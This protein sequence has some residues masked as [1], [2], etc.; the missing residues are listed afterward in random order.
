MIFS[1]QSM[2]WKSIFGGNLVKNATSALIVVSAILLGGFGGLA[3]A[4]P[5]AADEVGP[6]GEQAP[7]LAGIKEAEALIIEAEAAQDEARA[8]ELYSEAAVDLEKLSDSGLSPSLA[9]RCLTLA[10]LCYHEAKLPSKAVRLYRRLVDEERFRSSEHRENALLFLADSYQQSF[11]FDEASKAYL[12]YGEEY[13]DGKE[14]RR[15][16][17]SAA[18]LHETAEDYLRAT[19]AV[20]RFIR[21]FPKDETTPKMAYVLIALYEKLGDHKAARRAAKKF[22][23]KFG[24]VAAHSNSSMRATLKLGRWAAESGESSAARKFFKRVVKL[25]VSN[26]KMPASRAAKMAAEAA[27]RLTPPVVEDYRAIRISGKSSKQRKLL[28]SKRNKLLELESALGNVA[29]YDSPDWKIAAIY[30]VGLLW[31]DLAGSLEDAPYPTDLPK[32]AELMLVYEEQVADIVARF[33]DKARGLWS[34]GVKVAKQ[35]GVCNEWSAKTLVALRKFPEERLRFPVARAV[36]VERSSMWDGLFRERKVEAPMVKGADPQ[37]WLDNLQKMATQKG[38]SGPLELATARL[39]ED[40]VDVEA[41]KVLGYL[42]YK[43]GKRQTAKHVFSNALSMAPDDH[44]LNYCLAFLVEEE[45]LGNLARVVDSYVRVLAT[46]P[47]HPEAL[48]NNGLLFLK[49]RQYDGA[50]R[51]FRQALQQ[52]PA[53]RGPKLN[54]ATAL[55]GAGDFEEAEKLYSEL[56]LEHPEY[57]AAH[58]NRG[59]LYLEDAFG[60]LDRAARLE[61]AAQFFNIYVELMG[62]RLSA[63]DPAVGY[64]KEATTLAK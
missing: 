20:E 44:E 61:K 21:L 33:R 35:S 52:T 15:A 13:R 7:Y 6:S 29:K 18:L 39:A 63:D 48:N 9:A 55:R 40:Q 38:L 16:L 10:A 8:R 46:N 28:E 17:V 56:V 49:I 59:L 19:E 31:D 41:M 50:A 3:V 23:K 1:L 57:P 54:L 60:D 64:V 32:E 45:E 62:E 53:A 5:V 2:C 42:Y 24:S 37:S 11:G 51:L 43:M 27:F 36:M 12:R 30:R 14:V 25:F 22:L 58:F 34:Q 4:L 26:G 47:D